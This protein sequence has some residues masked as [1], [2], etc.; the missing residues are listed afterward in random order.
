MSHE[1]QRPSLVVPKRSKRT[2]IVMPIQRGFVPISMATLLPSAKLGFEVFVRAAPGLPSTK[3]FEATDSVVCSKLKKYI[4]AGVTSAFIYVDDRHKYQAY[5]R[6][7][8]DLIVAD[9]Y[10]CLDQ[11]LGVMSEVVRGVIDRQFQ[12]GDIQSLIRASNKVADTTVKLLSRNEVALHQLCNV[13]QHDYGTFTHSANVSFYAVLL[14]KELGYDE[15]VQHEIAVGALLHDVGKLHIDSKIINKPGPLNLQEMSEMKRHPTIGFEQLSRRSDVTFA[16]LMM[17]YQHHER[18]DGSGY[19]C[20]LPE[21]HIH[22]YAKLC[23]I[24]DVFEALTSERPYRKPMEIPAVMEF[25]SSRRGTEFD[26]N[27]LDVWLQLTQRDAICH[28]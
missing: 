14:A 11:R 15:Q 24:V 8:W 1:N 12:G 3:L 17:A 27:M 19:P 2:R 4:D 26:S 28:V 22:P 18:L 16:Q 21:K 6:E 13:L 20:S 9:E 25:L 23:A 10:T 5:L 7:N